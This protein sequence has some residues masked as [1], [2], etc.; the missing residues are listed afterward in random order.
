MTTVRPLTTCLLLLAVSAFA[1]DPGQ[2]ADF[3]EKD[4]GGATARFR[5]IVGR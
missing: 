5:V 2:K 1:G 4:L 3:D